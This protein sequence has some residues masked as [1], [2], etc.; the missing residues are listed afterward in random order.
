MPPERL[1]RMCTRAGAWATQ[2]ATTACCC[3][4]P[5]RT[6]RSTCPQAQVGRFIRYVFTGTAGLG[7]RLVQLGGRLQTDRWPGGCEAGWK[8][9][10]LHP[11]FRTAGAMKALPDDRIEGIVGDI[12]P[13][14]R[15][16]VRGGSSAALWREGGSAAQRSWPCCSA[17]V[18]EGTAGQPRLSPNLALPTC[19]VVWQLW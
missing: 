10:L 12:R 18:C 6:D 8:A 5:S 15:R 4:W 16:Q 7:G 17:A 14:L 9:A 11:L 19:L 1:P 3:C 2:P 13:L